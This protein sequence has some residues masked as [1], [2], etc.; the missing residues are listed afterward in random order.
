[1]SFDS[2]ISPGASVLSDSERN[3]NPC[4]VYPSDPYISPGGFFIPPDYRNSLSTYMDIQ[5]QNAYGMSANPYPNIR[6]SGYSIGGHPGVNSSH[7]ESVFS[8]A[9]QVN[10]SRPFPGYPYASHLHTAHQQAYNQGGPGNGFPG[11]NIYPSSCAS[12]PNEGKT[13]ADFGLVEQR[14]VVVSWT[15]MDQILVLRDLMMGAARKVEPST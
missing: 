1:M 4:D 6:S 15:D 14:E 8:A 9:A 2:A 5:Q 11:L 7:H 3:N 10:S 13:P 12:P